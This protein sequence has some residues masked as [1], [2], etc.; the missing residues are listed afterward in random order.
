MVEVDFGGPSSFIIFYLKF[1][2]DCNGFVGAPEIVWIVGAP[3]LVTFL[4]HFLLT[5][6]TSHSAANYTP[7]TRTRY[8]SI[9][10]N[11]VELILIAVLLKAAL[12]IH[13][14]RIR[15]PLLSCTATSF[16]FSLP[17]VFPLVFPL[18]HT[19]FQVLF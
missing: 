8:H 5:P 9:V 19:P 15:P 4:L 3:R 13:Y 16:P 14:L 2:S 1:N 11:A 6:V 12:R 7:L 17:L 10:S 18:L